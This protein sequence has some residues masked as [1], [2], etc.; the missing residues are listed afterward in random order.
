MGKD[1]FENFKIAKETFEEASDAAHIN[2]KKLCFDGPDA[3]RTLTLT[4]NTQP[5]LL[6]RLR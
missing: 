2:I 5:C 1:L 4:E 3:D 6:S